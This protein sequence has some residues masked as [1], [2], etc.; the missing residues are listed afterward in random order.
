[1]NIWH[2]IDPK[3]ISENEFWAVIEISKGSKMKYEL[4]KKT[5]MLK[6]DRI[7]HTP[8]RYPA[9]YGFIPRTYAEDKDPL[10]VLVVCNEVIA[11]LT[12]VKC[13]PVG[14]IN[15]IDGGENDYKI[16][17][18]LT[19]DPVYNSFS[20][21]TELPEH[22][23]KE[24]SHFFTVYKDLEGKKTFVSGIEGKDSAKKIIGDCILAY[25]EK[26]GTEI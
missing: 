8:T 4:D 23:F 13:K 18:V 2:D 24:M 7:L 16:L 12:L 14:V 20:D 11:P 10:D 5:G 19:D 17:A 21:Y 26:F 3:K 15:M 6:L 1:M 22:I 9:N 25:K